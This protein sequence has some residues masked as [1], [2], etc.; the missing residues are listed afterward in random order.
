MM[1]VAIIGNSHVGA[2]LLAREAIMAAFPSVSLSFF[3]LP[4]HSFSSCTYDASGVL[5]ARETTHPKL[6]QQIDLSAQ[7]AI[8]MVG[9][10]FA[11]D[12]LARLMAE[13]D[14]LGGQSTGK[15]RTISASL[16][17]EFIDHR[18][19]RYCRK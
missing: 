5:H 7:E 11:L 14:L 19:A 3:A 9:Q 4:R 15:D 6:P 18:V 1:R 17:T 13:F 8:L 12:G 10:S 16:V 2:Y